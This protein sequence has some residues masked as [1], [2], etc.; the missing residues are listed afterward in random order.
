MQGQRTLWQ[1]FPPIPSNWARKVTALCRSFF[2]QF[3]HTG[4]VRS[5]HFVAAFSINFLK[6]GTWWQLSPSMSPREFGVQGKRIC[7]LLCCQCLRVNSAAGKVTRRAGSCVHRRV[8]MHFSKITSCEPVFH[9]LQADGSAGFDFG[10]LRRFTI[11]SQ[12]MWFADTILQIF[13]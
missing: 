5:P 9:G 10:S 7:C 4:H 12:K 13:R 1:L 6:L 8:H 2:H 11:F 3:P